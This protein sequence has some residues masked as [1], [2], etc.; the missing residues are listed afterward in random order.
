MFVQDQTLREL[1]TA[2]LSF[3]VDIAAVKRLGLGRWLENY[4]W[5]VHWRDFAR[6]VDGLQP[7]VRPIGVVEGRV[8]ASELT[9]AEA[10]VPQLGLNRDVVA[11]R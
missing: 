2:P 10:R 6:F 8:Q 5:P 7:R 1:P 11:V 4:D 9:V 3:P